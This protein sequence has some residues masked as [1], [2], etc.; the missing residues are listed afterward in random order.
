[1]SIITLT[2][3]FGT[4]DWYVACM[5]GVILKINPRAVII[6]ISHECPSQNINSAAYII[7]N[8]DYFP[9]N[10][11]HVVVVDPEVGSARLPIIVE[12]S[13]HQLYVLPNNGLLTFLLQKHDL[14]SAHVLENKE[15]MLPEQSCTFHGRDV[16]APAAAYAS[17]GTPLSSFGSVVSEIT[18]LRIKDVKI[19]S[20]RI[21]GQIVYVDK[22]GNLISN[23]QKNSIVGEIK[24]CKIGEGLIKNIGV[25]YCDAEPLQSLMLFSSEGYVEVSVNK[26]NAAEI[27]GCGIGE[28]VILEIL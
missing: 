12:L 23:I 20:D 14:V 17:L 28:E 19:D 26:G 5:K 9:S 22:F 11:I 16:F 10:T 21:V 24:N 13:N 7:S 8:A 6:D 3:D 15:F 2:T 18:L 25:K 27:L 4:K 1:M